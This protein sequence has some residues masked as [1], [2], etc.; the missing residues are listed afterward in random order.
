MMYQVDQ[1]KMPATLADP[2]LKKYIAGARFKQD[3][4]SGKYQYVPPP[5]KGKAGNAARTILVYLPVDTGRSSVIAAFL[6][7]HIESMSPVRFERTLK[8]QLDAGSAVD[9][10]KPRR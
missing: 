6:D 2:K 7:G 4:A 9:A 1:G 10:A 8:A 5:A 3:L